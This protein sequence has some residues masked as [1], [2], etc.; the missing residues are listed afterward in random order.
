MSE[1][2]TLKLSTAKNCDTYIVSYTLN[3]DFSDYPA[4]G[5]IVYI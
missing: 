5:N 3:I 2:I 4:I 1:I